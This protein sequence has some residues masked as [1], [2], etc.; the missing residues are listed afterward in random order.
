[1]A[2]S[3]LC[4][5]FTY[6]KFDICHPLCHLLLSPHDSYSQEKQER[7]LRSQTYTYHTTM[8]VVVEHKGKG[9]SKALRLEASMS[10]VTSHEEKTHYKGMRWV[11]S[12]IQEE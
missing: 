12:M 9:A 1:M 7:T 10:L 4:Q 3:P 11:V 2:S 8:M 5:T 6:N